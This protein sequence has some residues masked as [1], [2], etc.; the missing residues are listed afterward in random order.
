MKVRDHF[1]YLDTDRRA[2]KMDVKET[3][4]GSVMYIHLIQGSAHCEAIVNTL[5]NHRV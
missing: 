5:R 3:K 4:C 1:E 2:I